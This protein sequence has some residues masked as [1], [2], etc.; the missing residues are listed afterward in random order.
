MVDRIVAQWGRERPDLDVSPVEIFGRIARIN[1]LLAKFVTDFLVEHGLTLGLFD[2]LTALRRSGEPFKL[3]PSDLADMTMLTS[4]GITGRLDHL[5]DLGFVQR[6]NDKR[7]RRVMFA[8]LTPA[9]LLLIDEVIAEH[10][11]RE[12]ILLQDIEEVDQSYLSELLKMLEKCMNE[13]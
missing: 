5:E 12:A 2:V 8:Q 4:G 10:F 13:K 11:H 7:D 6:I 9:G 3:K 1:L